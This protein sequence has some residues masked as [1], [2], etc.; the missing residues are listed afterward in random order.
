AEHGLSEVPHR[1][2]FSTRAFKQCG[3]RY[4]PPAAREL[5]HG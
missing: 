3:G 1:L 4:A 5:A 2:L